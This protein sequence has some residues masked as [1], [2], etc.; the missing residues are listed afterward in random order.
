MTREIIKRIV[1]RHR[2]EDG[3][4]YL[5]ISQFNEKTSMS[6]DKSIKALKSEF[7]GKIPGIILDLRGNPGRAA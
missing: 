5:R 6:L 3:M 7:G 2:V 4:G 1:V